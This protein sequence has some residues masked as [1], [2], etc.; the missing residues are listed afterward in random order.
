MQ[1]LIV[2]CIPIYSHLLKA[3]SFYLLSCQTAVK[4]YTS[5]YLTQLV[6]YL[7]QPWYKID[8]KYT[9]INVPCILAPIFL[10]TFEIILSLPSAFM[11]FILIL[12]F[13][14]FGKK[15]ALS[16]LFTT[17]LVSALIFGTHNYKEQGRKRC[18]KL[19]IFK[20]NP[21]IQSP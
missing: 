6:V 10:C 18:L 7:L 2:S 21:Y 8:V 1:V 17:E 12:S 9:D 4:H 14:Q 13:N 15:N 16:A 11:P 3:H 20:Q 19:L 5:V